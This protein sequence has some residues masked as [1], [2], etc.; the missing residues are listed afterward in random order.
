MMLRRRRRQGTIL[1]EAA[2]VYPV[3]FMI[4][5]TIIVL[6]VGVFRYQQVAHAAREGA[7]YAAVHGAKYASETNSPAATAQ[8]VFDN[9]IKPQM[10]GTRGQN[11]T[12]TVTWN[13]S[14]T[15]TTTKTVTVGGVS[16]VVE[17]ANTVSVTVTYAWNTHLFGTIPVSST[18]VMVMCY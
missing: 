8:D 14:N 16:K 5:L 18:S 2:M 4:L 10:G 11:I 17:K 12:Y 7:R 15:P 13:T 3:L 6:G 1:L 9:A